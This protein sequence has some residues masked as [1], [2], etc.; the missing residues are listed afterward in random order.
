VLRFRRDRTWTR[1]LGALV[2]ALR[3][4]CGDR[5]QV[6]LAAVPP[7]H[8]FPALPQPLRWALGARARLLDMAAA[9]W[10]AHRPGVV[11]V[12]A[13]ALEAVADRGMFAADGFHPSPEGYRAWGESLGAVA[14]GLVSRG[15]G[16]AASPAA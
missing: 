8:R 5:V 14:A 10:A 1:D 12:P 13:S 7:L 4:R 6:V 11:H 16:A 2:A 15:R 3:A 9:G